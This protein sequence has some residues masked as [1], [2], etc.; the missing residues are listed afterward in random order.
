MITS[1]CD[2]YVHVLNNTTQ[3]NIPTSFY[4]FSIVYGN[5]LAKWLT[6]ALGVEG[7]RFNPRQQRLVQ[8]SQPSEGGAVAMVT[9]LALK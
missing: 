6:D 9:E 2:S 3:K 7:L 1:S 8:L 5:R 4:I